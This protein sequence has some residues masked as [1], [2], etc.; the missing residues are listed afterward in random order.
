VLGKTSKKVVEASFASSFYRQRRERGVC[1]GGLVRRRQGTGGLLV[2]LDHGAV[3]VPCPGSWP[4]GLKRCFQT[5]REPEVV[6][7]TLFTGPAC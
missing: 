2:R 7:A 1:G 4:V 5:W 3:F 6:W